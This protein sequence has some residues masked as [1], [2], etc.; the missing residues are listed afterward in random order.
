M[1]TIKRIQS[2]KEEIDSFT[3]L[4]KLK[5][6]AEGKSSEY[7]DAAISAI[8]SKAGL[9]IAALPQ[10]T[11]AVAIATAL[12][13]KVIA[14]DVASIAEKATILALLAQKIQELS[15]QPIS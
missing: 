15:K 6:Y 11:G 8:T 13:A 4:E 12:Q 7:K 5:S 1:P 9:I 14:S 10:G 3:S 2:I